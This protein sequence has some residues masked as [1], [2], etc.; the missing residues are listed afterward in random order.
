MEQSC[1]CQTCWINAVELKVRSGRSKDQAVSGNKSQGRTMDRGENV[2]GSVDDRT[3][4]RGLTVVAV[5]VAVVDSLGFRSDS[6]YI[7]IIAYTSTT[8]SSVAHTH[9]GDE[10]GFTLLHGPETPLRH[11]G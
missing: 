7:H 10:S 4:K 2:V 3:S 6:M 5:Q 8:I 9:L 11:H 1:I